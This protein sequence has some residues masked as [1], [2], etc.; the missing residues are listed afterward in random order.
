M[1]TPDLWNECTNT[2]V[3]MGKLDMD[4]LERNCKRGN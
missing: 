3:A 1:G 2:F 4:V